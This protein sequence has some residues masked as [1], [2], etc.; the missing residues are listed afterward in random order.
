[1]RNGLEK[2][3]WIITDDP[4]RI[5]AGGADMEIDLGAEKVIAAEKGEE[6]IAIEIKS[7]IGA[8]NIS[9]FHTAMGQFINYRVALEERDPDR[10]LYLAV[11]LGVYRRFFILPFVQT[12]IKRFQ[13]K[14][15]V[16][17]PVNEVLLEWKN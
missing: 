8:S 6:K 14:L 3:G 1:M 12:I 10:I 2:E 9:D 4:L 5:K 13:I 16:Y 17:D 11:P 15:I 7:F